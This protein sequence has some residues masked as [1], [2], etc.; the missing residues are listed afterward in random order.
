MANVADEFHPHALCLLV[1]ARGGDTL[2]AR[3]DLAFVMSAARSD[4]P[5]TRYRVTSFIE[6][7]NR[8]GQ[9]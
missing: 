8:E 5:A 9:Q 3:K 7:V 6:T 1:K 2:A 4:E